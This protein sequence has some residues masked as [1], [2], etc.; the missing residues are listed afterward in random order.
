MHWS[1]L[2]CKSC[3]L[4]RHKIIEWCFSSSLNTSVGVSGLSSQW[5]VNGVEYV[6]L[7][8][9]QALLII[10]T[11]CNFM[12]SVQV[13]NCCAGGHFWGRRVFVIVMHIVIECIVI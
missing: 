9:L 11:P 2:V 13:S 7:S 6:H 3:S 12:I 8:T 5:Q 1:A 10:N 4:G